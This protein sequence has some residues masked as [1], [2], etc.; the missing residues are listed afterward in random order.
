[1][2]HPVQGEL[3]PSLRGSA[4]GDGQGRARPDEAGNHA[5]N[6][7]QADRARKYYS[8]A[9]IDDGDRRIFRIEDGKVWFVDVIP[10]ADIGK[11]GKPIPNLFQ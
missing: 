11:Y 7:H 8:E 3:S 9:G 5:W 2:V 6:A 10:H 1:V 4:E